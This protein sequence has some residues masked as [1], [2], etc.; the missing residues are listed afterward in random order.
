MNREVHVRFWEGLGVRFPRA[1]RLPPR[2]RERGRGQAEPGEVL[3]LLQR[4][5]PTFIVE[6]K[7][8]GYGILHRNANQNRSMMFNPQ[9]LH[10]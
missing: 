9:G 3:Q 6:R 5:P 8:S 4:A 7:N 10:L 1:T 2:L